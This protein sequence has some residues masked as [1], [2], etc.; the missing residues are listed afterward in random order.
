MPIKNAA[1]K[2]LRKSKKHAI[3]NKKIISDLTALSK[4]VRK[5]VSGKDEAKAKEW[6]KG[7]IKA[8]DKAAQKGIIKKNNAARKKS[9]LAKLVSTLGKNR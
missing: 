4:R 2:A 5:A 7:A 1:F 8:F 6:L 3:L 9:R